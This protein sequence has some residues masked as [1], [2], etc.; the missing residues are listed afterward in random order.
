MILVSLGLRKGFLG[1]QRLGGRQRMAATMVI[2]IR[3][4]LVLSLTGVMQTVKAAG[5]LG[6][7][8]VSLCGSRSLLAGSADVKSGGRRG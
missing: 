2:N 6:S 4:G 7:V 1:E 3:P 5:R 8:D